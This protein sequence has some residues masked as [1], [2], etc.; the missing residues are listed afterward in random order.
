MGRRLSDD[1]QNEESTVGIY[2]DPFSDMLRFMCSD[3]IGSVN[4]YA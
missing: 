2:T 3:Y 4:T 1:R